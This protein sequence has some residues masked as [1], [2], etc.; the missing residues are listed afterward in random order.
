VEWAEY[1]SALLQHDKVLEVVA[2]GLGYLRQE[3]ETELFL[4]YSKH[5]ASANYRVGNLSASH[6]HV[7]QYRNALD[8]IGM[9]WFFEFDLVKYASIYLRS[10]IESSLTRVIELSKDGIQAH[11]DDNAKCV[12]YLLLRG[13]AYARRQDR[14]AAE[15]TINEAIEIAVAFGE[16]NLMMRVARIAGYCND[17]MNSPDEALEAFHQAL[18]LSRHESDIQPWPE[19]LFLTHISIQNKEGPNMES[20]EQALRILPEAL[21]QMDT[22]WELRSTLLMLIDLAAK[23]EGAYKEMIRRQSLQPLIQAASQRDDCAD[24]LRLLSSFGQNQQAYDKVS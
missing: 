11:K 8:N 3:P 20:M 24:A 19:E 12:E 15:N 13:Q 14:E 7:E 2:T 5:A 22:W 17:I 1:Y 4:D 9:P 21:E 23:D 10:E 16:R 6:D 18:E